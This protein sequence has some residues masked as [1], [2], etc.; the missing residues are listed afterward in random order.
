MQHMACEHD[1]APPA[2]E[3]AVAEALAR[4]QSRSL[5]QGHRWTEPRRRVYELLLR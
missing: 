3:G 4:A 5:E 1:H 2:S